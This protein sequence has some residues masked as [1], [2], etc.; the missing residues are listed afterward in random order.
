M[1]EFTVIGSG[2]PA[3]RV[4]EYIAGLELRPA[5][6]WLISVNNV[7]LISERTIEEF[8]GRCLNLHPAP[9]PEYA[10]LYCHYWG[11]ANKASGWAA[12][13][14]FVAPRIDTGD[15][16]A[17]APLDIGERETPQTL[18]VRSMV[19]GVELMYQV[20]DDI[21][22]GRPLERRPQDLSRRRLYTR[23]MAETA[24]FARAAV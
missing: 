13:V 23:Q 8:G 10:G 1:S 18:F 19:V 21:V 4:A 7:E 17:T 14:H 5:E 24:G 3:R 15:I 6:T 12:T 2:G 11:M 20:L 16:V 9:L 22:A